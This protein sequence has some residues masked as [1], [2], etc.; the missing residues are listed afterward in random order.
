MVQTPCLTGGPS[1]PPRSSP[2]V[3]H[4][5]SA[6][7]DPEP[8]GPAP[9]KQPNP[10]GP[11]SSQIRE[12]AVGGGAI[13]KSHPGGNPRHKVPCHR[14]EGDTHQKGLCRTLLPCEPCLPAAR[15][16]RF[17]HLDGNKPAAARTPWPSGRYTNHSV[18][19][20]GQSPRTCSPARGPQVLPTCAN[21]KCSRPP[22]RTGRGL[23]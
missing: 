19:P 20:S 16:R 9:A 17:C 23:Q 11:A 21:E 2:A 10:S 3:P 12:P 1:P 13:W 5:R 14:S 18:R 7:P 8:P 6:Q 22:W 4:P 15:H